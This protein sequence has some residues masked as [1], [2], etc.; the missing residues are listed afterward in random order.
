MPHGDGHLPGDTESV[1]RA[2][3]LS[4]KQDDKLPVRTCDSVPGQTVEATGGDE[5]TG[6][7]S[8]CNLLI[9]HEC[10]SP[11]SGENALGNQSGPAAFDS[12]IPRF[13]SWRPSQQLSNWRCSENSLLTPVRFRPNF[14]HFLG[15]ARD[16]FDSRDILTRRGAG[17]G[18]V[19]A[20]IPGI[21]D[22]FSTKAE[23]CSL[24]GSA[25]RQRLG[26]SACASGRRSIPD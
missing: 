19:S 1:A 9:Q 3:G 25:C 14:R 10:F 6:R 12:A 11:Q 23:Q 20:A 15:V 8:S 17:R 7:E 21:K 16:L 18:R 4:I 26:V 24:F 2:G 13:E 5:W 22:T